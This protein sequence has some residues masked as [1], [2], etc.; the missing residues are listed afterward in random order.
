MGQVNVTYEI[1]LTVDKPL[2]IMSI[3]NN[4]ITIEEKIYDDEIGDQ[5]KTSGSI[6][7]QNVGEGVLSVEMEC[8]SNLLLDS[9]NLEIE[10]KGENSVS[11]WLDPNASLA[12][13]TH[14]FEIT[15]TDTVNDISET[16]EVFY[17]VLRSENTVVV[18]I[19]S[20]NAKVNN[21]LTQLDA[22]PYIKS[23]TTMVPLRLV[24]E[25]LGFG[26]EWVP[27]LKTIII[28]LGGNRFLRLVIDYPTAIIEEPDGTLTQQELIV[29]PE[30]SGGRT[31]VPLR[32]IGEIVGAEVEWKA[33][34]KQVTLT[35]SLKE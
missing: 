20:K 32:F 21:E 15:V 4:Q 26:L 3:A 35:R 11:F 7:I 25:G 12:P 33:E 8:D 1:L 18:W 22:P 23:G 19:G 14:K 30:I 10:P 29:A 5:S 24:S 34:T 16:V 2:P 28:D 6:L 27:E 9:T 17:E 13:G 31:F